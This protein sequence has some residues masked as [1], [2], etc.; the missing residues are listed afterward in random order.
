MAFYTSVSPTIAFGLMITLLVSVAVIC[1]YR[2]MK[3]KNNVFYAGS[4]FC[5]L[6]AFGFFG[7]YIGQYI[8][9]TIILVI[10]GVV[11]LFLSPKMMQINAKNSA[12][13]FTKVQKTVDASEPIRFKELFSTSGFIKLERKYGEHRAMLISFVGGVAIA[14]PVLIAMVLLR[15]ATWYHVIVWGFGFG[16]IIWLI[17]YRQMK[18]ELQCMKEDMLA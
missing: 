3:T 14:S 1:I 2:G 4:G 16:I 7:Y 11:G 6:M 18:R 17:M 8:L 13:E 15:V 9:G 5:C 12:E 10:S